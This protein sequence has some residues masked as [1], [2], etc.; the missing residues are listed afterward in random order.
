M[1]PSRSSSLVARLS[2]AALVATLAAPLPARAQASPD[3][4]HPVLLGTNGEDAALARSA[5]LSW[6]RFTLRWSEVEPEPGRWDFSKPDR[7]VAQARAQG[8]ELLAILSTAPEWAGSNRNGTRPPEEV[9]LW[10]TFVRTVA[11]RYRGKIAAYEIWNEPNFF[12]LGLGIG[13]ARNLDEPPRYI[14]YLRIAAEEI[15]AFAPGT[16]VVGPVTSSRV[17]SRTGTL[18]SQLEAVFP[19]GRRAA[20]FLDVVSFHAN[21]LDDETASEVE[22][23][24]SRHLS[25]LEAR[26]PSS[27]TKPVWVTEMGWKT[28]RVGERGQRDSIVAVLGS[29]SGRCAP[30]RPSLVFLFQTSDL[31]GVESR[32]LFRADGTPKLVVSTY[33]ATLPFP[34]T[35]RPPFDRPIAAV[36]AAR[37]CSF[38]ATE[39]LANPFAEAVCR[40]DFGDGMVE[41]GTPC[42]A[43]HLYSNDESRVVKLTVTIDGVVV[44]SV[45]LRVEPRSTCADFEPPR[46]AITAPVSGTDLTGTFSVRYDFRDNL[47]FSNVELVVDGRTVVER[48]P[49]PFQLLFETGRFTSGSHQ[50]QVALTDLCGNRTVSPGVGVVIDR[51]PPLV[52]ITSPGSGE[53]VGG[54]VVVTAEASDNRAVER[55]EL[56]VGRRLRWVD[57][58]RPYELSWWSDTSAPGAQTLEVRAFDR[59]GNRRDALPVSVVNDNQPPLLALAAPSHG[60]SVSGLVRVAGW[61]LDPTGVTELAFE[62]DGAPLQLAWPLEALPR[63]TVCAAFPDLPDPRC[64]AVGFRAHFDASG[65]A[66]GPHLLEVIARDGAGLERVVEVGLEMGAER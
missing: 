45:D 58:T 43:T 52:S 5:R 38:E 34:A 7:L 61:A 21:A 31:P 64:P 17:E 42:R 24:A 36:C 30:P 23:E 6:Q 29:F 41:E 11:E 13:W 40:W 46:V 33:L 15:R 18:F 19:D 57:S 8:L 66:P 56:W 62:L 39:W 44:E 16:L 32:G 20:E 12:D 51:R 25:L 4:Y 63:P 49:P 53:A 65:L 59:A 55:L 28:N 35:T 9:E 26:S 37:E 10:R 27:A 3:C 22:G 47:G 50:L 60:A 54:R 14:D 48:A 2:V 1:S